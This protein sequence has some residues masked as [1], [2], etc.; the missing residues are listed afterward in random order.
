MLR[1]HHQHFLDDGWTE[2][3]I[4][5]LVK[6]GVRSVSR[7]EADQLRGCQSP[8]GGIWFPFAG[9]FGQ[10]RP[11]TPWPNSGKYLGAAGEASSDY[12]WLPPG[13]TI[14]STP[15][16]EGF[17]DAAF[18][19]IRAGLPVAAIPGVWF[20]EKVVPKGC[21]CPIIFDSDAWTN[22]GVLQALIQGALHTGGSV[23]IVPGDPAAKRGLSE[24]LAGSSPDAAQQLMAELLASALPPAN[25]FECWID[26]LVAEPLQPIRGLGYGDQRLAPGD[27]EYAAALCKKI[28]RLGE[29]VG[30][31][32]AA[33]TAQERFWRAYRAAL[34]AKLARQQ[35]YSLDDAPVGEFAPLEWPT[36]RTMIALNGTVGTAKTSMGIFGLVRAGLE[37]DKRIL[38]IAPT[39]A[40]CGNTAHR[41]RQALPL[42]ESQIC[43]HLEEGWERSDV[44]IT[45]PESL[46]KAAE[47][48]WDAVVFD[49]VNESIPRLIEGSLCRA[50]RA[51][52]AA[53]KEV[54]AQ[55]HAIVLAQDT[56][57]RPVV[58]L[59][60]RLAGLLIEEIQF[61]HRRRPQASNEIILY[62]D[63]LTWAEA[64]Q[65]AQANDDRI[66]VPSASQAKLRQIEEWLGGEG[67]QIIDKPDTESDVRAAFMANPDQFIATYGPR[68]LG[69]SPT[70]NSGLSMEQL[71]FHKQ[72]EYLSAKET[73]SSALQRGARY[74]PALDQVPRHIYSRNGGI[75]T[76]AASIPWEV[77]SPEYW[78]S[79]LGY[80]NTAT[81]AARLKPLGLDEV[82]RLTLADRLALAVEFPE[83]AEIKAIQAREVYFKSE[84]LAAEFTAAGYR[85][86]TAAP[87]DK[88]AK[89]K[90]SAEL[91]E[92]Q[93][94]VMGRNSQHLSKA[95]RIAEAEVKVPQAI[96]RWEGGLDPASPTEGRW[97]AAWDM[98]RKLGDIQDLDNPE[99]WGAGYLD[100]RGY[101]AA[102]QLRAVLKLA[103]EDP[104]QF[105]ELLEWQALRA[106]A[107]SPPPLPCPQRS[108]ELAV[109]LQHCPGLRAAVEGEMS[110][111][112]K[113][114]PI[115]QAAKRWAIANAETLARLTKH[116][117][118]IHGLQFTPKTYDVQVLSRLLGL[119]GLETTKDGKDGEVRI[120]RLKTATDVEALIAK[121]QAEGKDSRKEARAKWRLEN[122]ERLLDALSAQIQAKAAATAADWLREIEALA[123]T[124]SAQQRFSEVFPS[125]EALPQPDLPD[126]PPLPLRP[127]AKVRRIGRAG[128]TGC[129]EGLET[130]GW[131][132]VRWFGD[133]TASS[134]PLIELQAV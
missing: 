19:T 84:C 115:I 2:S 3:E 23:A 127:G 119:L 110:E 113:N 50:P 106:I 88:A 53:L 124:D 132:L 65:Q 67:I 128:W 86:T 48:R 61:I 68:L 73:A 14:G 20:V 111:W 122:M 100:A 40:L 17:K 43:T 101:I 28:L 102:L 134:V 13:A 129:F 130:A 77:L 108:L 45:C 18:P 38:I 39:Q 31:V 1:H 104:A 55:A 123:P 82:A 79:I 120:Y 133:A 54:L 35:V 76:T 97:F 116:S 83:I 47:K 34:N 44:L 92:A 121:R 112:D 66:I 26:R 6:L 10:L 16:T 8:S 70:A 57:Y 5:Q 9:E 37:Q 60:A 56:L 80:D 99:F 117:Q 63:Y 27:D 131:A 24:Y 41:L 11:D 74:R 93:E 90:I 94:T 36:Q 51:A 78:R 95:P 71:Y 42:A 62:S 33:A 7:D 81:I 98:E 69:F 21:G 49:E 15:I 89:G 125:T 103:W 59:V 30:G 12:I 126:D 75:A 114:T 64:L 118:R 91:R 46:H 25:L 32:A 58:A 72:F 4:A 85:L 87:L 109:L 29:L 105:S 22:A 96:A 52:R 107:I